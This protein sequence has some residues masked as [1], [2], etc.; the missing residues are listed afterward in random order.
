MNDGLQMHTEQWLIGFEM[1]CI[2]EILGFAAILI[3][4]G[5]SLIT[6]SA[7]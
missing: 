1:K 6:Q 5:V 7:T 2:G 4:M 3:V